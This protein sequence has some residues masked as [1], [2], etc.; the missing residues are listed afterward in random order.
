[1]NGSISRSDVPPSHKCDSGHEPATAGVSL[2]IPQSSLEP[3]GNAPDARG[4]SNRSRLRF[5]K[6]VLTLAV[7]ALFLHGSCALQALPPSAVVADRPS[8]PDAP[9]ASRSRALPKP[10]YPRLYRSNS[11]LFRQIARLHRPLRAAFFFALDHCIIYAA[12]NKAHQ[13]NVKRDRETQ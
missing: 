8:L 6:A 13:S 5:T 12:I 1:M 3:I 10:R 9:D 4:E 11:Q 2:L 7:L